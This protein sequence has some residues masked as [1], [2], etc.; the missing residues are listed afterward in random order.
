M[1]YRVQIERHITYEV[2]VNAAS[3]EEAEATAREFLKDGELHPE[4]DAVEVDVFAALWC[5]ECETSHFG[6]VCQ[7]I[8]AW[9]LS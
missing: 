6:P 8:P 7:P 9:V 2:M 4:T 3:K 1:E 5:E